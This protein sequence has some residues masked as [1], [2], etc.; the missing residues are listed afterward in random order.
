MACLQKADSR[1]SPMESWLRRV[2][3][4]MELGAGVSDPTRDIPEPG[5]PFNLPSPTLA[6]YLIGGIS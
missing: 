4:V 5:Y 3:R 1:D 2:V 6:L